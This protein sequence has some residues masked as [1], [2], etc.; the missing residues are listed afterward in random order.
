MSKTYRP[1]EPDQ[2]SVLPPSLADWLPEDHQVYMVRDLTEETDLDP[3]T[4]VYEEERGYPPYHPKM[5]TALLLYGYANGVFSSRKLAPRCQEDVAFQVFT[6]NNQT[7][8]P[9]HRSVPAQAHQSSGHLYL[10]MLRVCTESGMVSFGHVS[11][12]GTKIKANASKHK[13]LSYGRMKTDIK[14]LKGEIN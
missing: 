2:M 5:M 14:R 11:L 8:F 9:D 1:F 3:I 10:E 13:A 12:D 4:S 6:A 7:D